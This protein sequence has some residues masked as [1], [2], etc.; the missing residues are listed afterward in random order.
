[1]IKTTTGNLYRASPVDGSAS[2]GGYKRK[3]PYTKSKYNKF[4][5]QPL[6]KVQKTQ[7]KAMLNRKDTISK[8]LKYI[9]MSLLNTNTGT[10]WNV[11]NL[12]VIPQGLLDSNRVG[13]EVEV[14]DIELRIR[15]Y[16]NSSAGVTNAS[17]VLRVVIAQYYE[18]TTIAA[19]TAGEFFSTTTGGS[20][21]LSTYNHD[22]RRTYKI[23]YDDS[24][25]V[26]A[27][28]EASASRV[29]MVKPGRKKIRFVGAGNNAEGHIILLT[30]S[31]TL[32]TLYPPTVDWYSRVNYVD[33]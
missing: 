26:N 8:E 32:S 19:L 3:A 7:I 14:K 2:G 15:T 4:M 12:T 22:T 31:D 29:I 17:S 13:D 6:S 33:G 16:V 18:D 23:L 21:Y 5:D 20:A 10:T 25:T 9:D 27:T 30:V 11:Y 1:M 28:G 24:M